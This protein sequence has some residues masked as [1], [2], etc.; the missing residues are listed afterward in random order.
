M[1]VRILKL[2]INDVKFKAHFTIVC[3]QFYIVS[4]C[5]TLKQ[6]NADI[7]Q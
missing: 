5:T 6:N 1:S 7:E 3:R 2:L 4:K